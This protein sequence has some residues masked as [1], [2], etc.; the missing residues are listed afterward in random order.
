MAWLAGYLLDDTN[1]E[2]AFRIKH[3]APVCEWI[4]N[5]PFLQ[6]LLILARIYPEETN[7]NHLISGQCDG[8]EGCLRFLWHPN[9]QCDTIFL[10]IFLRFVLVTFPSPCAAPHCS[11]SYGCLC[12]FWNIKMAL[13]SPITQNNV[14]EHSK[15]YCCLPNNNARDSFVCFCYFCFSPSLARKWASAC[16]KWIHVNK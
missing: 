14:P 1:N 3:S 16:V 2:H 9:L 8:C 15:K 13:F 12:T 6:R 7:S 10:F 5:T 4:Q 11:A